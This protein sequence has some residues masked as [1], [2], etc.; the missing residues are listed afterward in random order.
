MSIG[1]ISGSLPDFGVK[2]PGDRQPLAWGDPGNA[3]FRGVIASPTSL[4][5]GAANAYE[6]LLAT[7]RSYGLESLAPVLLQFFQDGLSEAEIN[8][9][10]TE[11][12][13]YKQRFAGNEERRKKGLPVLSPAEYLSVERSYRE[14]MSVAGLPPGFYDEPSDFTSWIANDV[15]PMEIQGRVRTAAEM[16]HSL[17]ENSLSEFRRYYSDGDIVA[18]ALDRERAASV[19]DRQWRASQIA[20]QSRLAGIESDIQFS[21]RLADMG[22]SRDDAQRGFS[23]AATLGKTV[24]RLSTIYGGDYDEQAAVGEVFLSDVEA[25]RTRKRLASRER[26]Q[27]GGSSGATS[28]STGTSTAGRI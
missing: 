21:E 19:L 7:L 25:G 5:P 27:F 15:S 16:V 28:A 11:T 2:P 20:S 9:R 22:I 24:G 4:A 17:D 12:D 8:I 18:Y 3:G 10:I 13:A 1:E 6:A 23:T 14:I 26:A